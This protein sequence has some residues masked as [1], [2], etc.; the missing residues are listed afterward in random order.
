MKLSSKGAAK[1]FALGYYLD[2]I[3]TLSKSKINNTQVGKQIIILLQ[4]IAQ[5]IQQIIKIIDINY[6]NR[7]IRVP[8]KYILFKLL[9]AFYCNLLPPGIPHR[10]EKDEKW[11]FIFPF[12][13]LQSTG[14]FKILF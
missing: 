12:G 2:Q 6:Y 1:T 14:I 10:D 11:C 8:K 4:P 13:S 3:G 7:I 9:T 5:I